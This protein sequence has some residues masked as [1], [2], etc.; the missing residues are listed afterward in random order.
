MNTFCTACLWIQVCFVDVPNRWIYQRRCKENILDNMVTSLACVREMLNSDY[1]DW[2][3]SWLYS[4]TK[5]MS[6]SY[7]DHFL[8]NC[9]Q[10]TAN[11][12]SPILCYVLEVLKSGIKSNY[13]ITTVSVW[14]ILLCVCVCVCVLQEVSVMANQSTVTPFIDVQWRVTCYI[15][16]LYS[17]N[18]N[19]NHL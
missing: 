12:L 17:S 8:P 9:C 18:R 2:S 7:H 11:Y 15:F 3:F 5:Q 10:L 13:I 19:T 6:R 16:R 1:S 14:D 4:V